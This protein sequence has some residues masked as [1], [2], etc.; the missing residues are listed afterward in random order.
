[1][2]VVAI[3]PP[4]SGN[5]EE[6]GP[7]LFDPSPGAVSPPRPL[8]APSET[9][10]VP[11]SRPD[12]TQ[13][14]RAV[15]R[16]SP[17]HPTTETPSRSAPSTSFGR[18]PASAFRPST[19]PAPSDLPRPLPQSAAARLPPPQAAE[20]SVVGP[21]SPAPG[22]RAAP[23]LGRPTDRTRVDGAR[24]PVAPSPA[25]PTFSRRAPT[26][27]LSQGTPPRNTT[28]PTRETKRGFR[29][30]DGRI[31]R[32]LGILKDEPQTE[33]AVPTTSADQT[34]RWWERFR[35]T[36]PRV[37]ERP[38]VNVPAPG[39]S[40]TPLETLPAPPA[41]GMPSLFRGQTAP[42]VA[43]PASTTNPFEK[44]G[45]SIETW[46]N[47]LRAK[48]KRTFADLGKPLA[49][50]GNGISPFSPLPQGT[51]ATSPQPPRV[52]PFSRRPEVWQPI[53]GSGS[54]SA[55][56][57]PPSR[58]TVPAAGNSSGWRPLLVRTAP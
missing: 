17:S 25:L 26:P 10:V 27:Y 6:P 29:L 56:W 22:A 20:P 48:I 38:S 47:D 19:E 55:R 54:T 15:E 30:G 21:N 18:V 44:A 4:T 14:W 41:S 11:L 37:T 13:G 7:L 53:S 24:Y 43:R 40:I 3:L 52:D 1:M 50:G 35:P 36:K 58:P 9:T 28:P 5:A 57:L 46:W 34:P 32:A 2:I 31:L 42:P 8:P 23:I 39:G 16:R 49:P 45:N 12:G 33:P 51:G